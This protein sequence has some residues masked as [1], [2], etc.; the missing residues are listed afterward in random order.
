MK[1]RLK[2]TP[3]AREL[4]KA[5][6]PFISTARQDNDGWTVGYGHRAAAKSGVTV[7]QEEAELLLVY[8]VLRAEQAIDESLGGDLGSPQ[9]DALVS[10]ALGI[11]LP[12]FRSSAVVRLIRKKRWLEAADAIAAWNGGESAR[13]QAERNLFLKDLPEEANRS[14]VELVI[15]FDHPDDEPEADIL[16][17]DVESEI[18]GAEP[19]PESEPEPEPEAEPE[20][21]PE[22]EPEAEPAEMPAITRAGPQR[23]ALAEQVIMRMRA[24]LSGPIRQTGYAEPEPVEPEAQPGPDS[25]STPE[26]TMSSLGFTFTQ[27]SDIDDE[28]P[29]TSEEPEGLPPIVGAG[30]VNADGAAG[31]V[32][33]AGD[34]ADPDDADDQDAHDDLPEPSEIDAEFAESAEDAEQDSWANGDS[35]PAPGRNGG[36]LGEVIVLILGLALLGGG[37]WDMFTRFNSGA[38]QPS[39]FFGLAALVAGFILAAGATIWLLGGRRK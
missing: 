33:G 5:H 23:S 12:A 32:S 18:A 22:P 28:E 21:E 30:A 2:S 9:R 31:E 34:A 7:G 35:K 3:A 39:L 1:P 37:G 36:H 24:Q 8:D 25:L 6:E 16:P 29:E 4:I 17:V 20:P 26:T 13:H 11:G 19:E 38:E 15:E 14:P 27:S 10:F